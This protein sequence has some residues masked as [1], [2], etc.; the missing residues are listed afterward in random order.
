VNRETF[1]WL[2]LLWSMWGALAVPASAAEPLGRLFYTPEQRATLDIARSKKTRVNL[3]TETAVEKPP[4]PPEPEIVRYGGV[5]RR[6]DG[7]ATV[8]LNNKPIN[9]KEIRSGATVV[10]SVRPDGSVLVQSQ[11]SGRRVDLKVGQSAELLS[12]TVEEGYA[13]RGLTSQKP[14]AHAAAEKA[15]AKPNIDVAAN[16][17]PDREKEARDRQRDVE[18]TLRA[19]QDAADRTAA[20]PAAPGQAGPAPAQTGVPLA[21]PPQSPGR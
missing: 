1:L 11:Q 14:P 19:L 8:W 2:L 18:D 9:E 4:P 5:V 20:T 15:A 7:K 6:S 12:G 21:Y 10:G 13:R 3:E 16:P 17:P